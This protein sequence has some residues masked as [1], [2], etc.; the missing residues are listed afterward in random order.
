MRIVHMDTDFLNKDKKTMHPK[1]F[2]AMD[3][4]FMV[5]IQWIHTLSA[6]IM[7]TANYWKMGGNISLNQKAMTNK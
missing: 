7:S 4:C 5:D 3:A 1:K 6:H 2:T